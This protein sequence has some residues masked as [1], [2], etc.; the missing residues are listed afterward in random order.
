LPVEN[1]NDEVKSLYEWGV[2]CQRKF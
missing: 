2:K 1:T